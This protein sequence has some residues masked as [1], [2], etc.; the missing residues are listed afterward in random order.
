MRFCS[1]YLIQVAGVVRS[2]V[3]DTVHGLGDALCLALQ[4]HDEDLL[5]LVIALYCLPDEGQVQ[6]YE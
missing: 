1:R 4:H 3:L 2:G 5:H 6:G